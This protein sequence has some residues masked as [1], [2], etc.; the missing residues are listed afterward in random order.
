MFRARLP[1]PTL[2]LIHH[3]CIHPPLYTLTTH[4]TPSPT[5]STLLSSVQSHVPVFTQPKAISSARGSIS[6]GGEYFLSIST[7]TRPTAFKS[8][9]NRR[10]LAILIAEILQN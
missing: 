3:D 2:Q 5:F 4:S 10:E 9:K 8:S 6:N 1:N 7:G